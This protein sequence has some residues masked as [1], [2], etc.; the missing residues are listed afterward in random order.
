MMDWFI[1]PNF[2]IGNEMH[3]D[4]QFDLGAPDFS[5]NEMMYQSRG[6]GKYIEIAALFGWDAVRKINQYYYYY[7]YYL[8]I[9]YGVERD[10]FI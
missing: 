9:S 2:R 8:G 5:G 3:I 7:Y 10:D 1:S 4:R 6:H